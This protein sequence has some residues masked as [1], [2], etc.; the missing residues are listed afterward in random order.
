MSSRFVSAGKIGSSGEISKDASG[1]ESTPQQPLHNSA[2]SKEWEAVEQQL[3]AE[4]KKREEQRIKAATGGGEKTLYDVLQA[5]KAAK[6]AEFEEQTKLRNQFRALDDDEIEFL[7]EIRANKRAE[8]ERVRQETEEGLKAF[9][10]R[11]KGDAAQGENAGVKE[12]GES[13][14]IG[15]KRKRT[16][17]KDVKGLRRKVSVAEEKETGKQ[18]TKPVEGTSHDTLDEKSRTTSQSAAKPPEKKGLVLVGY[19]SNSDDDD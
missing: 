1:A 15:R 13:W 2:K 14:E 12:E 8:E 7:D 3:E 10:E 11:Q 9:R 19:G 18:D 6:Q 4:R 5:N 17:E 16:K